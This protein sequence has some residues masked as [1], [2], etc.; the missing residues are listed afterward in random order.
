MTVMTAP[1]A[2]AEEIAGR[3]L[4][5]DALARLKRNRAAVVSLVVLAVIALLAVFAPILSPHPFDEV[6]FDE[7][8]APPNFAKAHWFGTDANGRDLFVPMGQ[9]ITPFCEGRLLVRSQQGGYRTTEE[10]ATSLLRSM[11]GIGE[12][13][14]SI[15]KT[16]VGQDANL[17][18]AGSAQ[19]NGAAPE[20]I[21]SSAERSYVSTS[22]CLASATTARTSFGKHE[23]P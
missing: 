8:G 22:G 1:P 5:Q 10:A 12:S 7:I 3:S 9:P 19:A 4:W 23:P 21:C 18:R 6:Y 16:T 11:G 2:A 14:I 13:L 17:E 20:K 15:Y